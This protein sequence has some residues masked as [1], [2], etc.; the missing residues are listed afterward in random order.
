MISRHFNFKM[1]TLLISCSILFSSFIYAQRNCGTMDVYASELQNNPGLASKRENIEG[2]IRQWIA[3]QSNSS[4]SVITIPVVVHVIYNTSEQNISDAQVQSQIDVLNEDYA[5][6]NADASQT[7]SAFQSIVANCE[8]QF[9]LAKTDP[10]NQATSGI[11]RTQTAAT[12]F[13][14]GSSM[15]YAATG[16]VN[17]WPTAKYL[18]IWVCNMANQVI[19]FATLPGT[20]IAAE[21]GVVIMYKHF[22]RTGNVVAPYHKGRTATHEVGHWLN[23]LHIWGDDDGSSN[24]C[25]GSDQVDD[26]PNQASFYFGCPSSPSISCS[27]TGDMFMNFMDYTDDACMNA[28]TIGQ[29]NR[30]LATLNSSRLLIQSSLACQPPII[31]Q[32][33]DTLNNVVGGDGINYYLSSEIVEGDT[34]YFTG[35][36]SNG[37]IAYADYHSV[38]EPSTIDNIQLDFVYAYSASGSSNLTIGIWDN[39]GIN[40]PGSP[41]TLLAETSLPYSQINSDIDNFSST[42][43][44]LPSSILINGGFF[45][46]FKNPENTSD[47]IAVYSNQI[48]KINV[49]TAWFQDADQ[50]WAEFSN[51]IPFNSPI[52]LAIRP[53]ICGTV[54]VQE[55]IQNPLQIYPNPSQDFVHIEFSTSEKSHAWQV[56]SMDGKKV[57]SGI[58]SDAHL[59]LNCT[60]L[61]QG[62]YVFQAIQNGKLFAHRIAIMR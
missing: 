36:N 31:Q 35:T 11:T 37:N 15:K 6:L 5:R 59:E 21:D 52:S 19:G 53:I 20:S 40:P 44:I 62:I 2:Q 27:N 28:F 42:E 57:L 51:P 23:L 55:F 49:N 56:F 3:T 34:G 48:D 60:D 50:Q 8:I 17:A 22:G 45:V 26:T 25:L 18:N 9:C 46:G 61:A 43:I 24:N 14:I 13:S 33:C 1:K 39:D 41:G 38:S 58:T 7:P 29:K 10:S 32:V 54:G 16:G 4:R 12:S 30:M 47:T